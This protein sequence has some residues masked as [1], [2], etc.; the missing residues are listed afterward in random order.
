MDLV[1]LS[2]GAFCGAALAAPVFAGFAKWSLRADKLESLFCR[3]E[4]LELRL[5][6]DRRVHQLV[7]INFGTRLRKLEKKAKK[8]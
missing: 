1:S 4:R 3:S 6:G 5:Q 7:M 2:V 8:S